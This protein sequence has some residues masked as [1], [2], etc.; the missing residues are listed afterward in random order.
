MIVVCAVTF[1]GTSCSVKFIIFWPH[2]QMLDQ[3]KS[4]CQNYFNCS[5]WLAN[6]LQWTSTHTKTSKIY[7]WHCI[8]E[9]HRVFLNSWYN[10]QNTYSPEWH[11]KLKQ[12]LSI[13]SKVFHYPTTPRVS[14]LKLQYCNE[15]SVVQQSTDS[16]QRA[17]DVSCGPLA[18]TV[19]CMLVSS[20]M[21]SWYIQCMCMR[22]LQSPLRHQH[23]SSF[24]LSKLFTWHINKVLSFD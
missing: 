23:I 16:A 24:R 2:H 17:Q 18:A 3:Q 19:T 6:R 1:V 14:A 20:C 7:F 12:Q 13:E 21:Q 5:C 22:P 8:D 10:H 4:A 9:Y 15:L 11:H